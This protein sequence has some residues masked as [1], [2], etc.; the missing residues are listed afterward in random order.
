MVTAHHQHQHLLVHHRRPNLD[1]SHRHHL[2]V[3]DRVPQCVRRV[4]HLQS[5]YSVLILIG[6]RWLA[7]LSALLVAQ[8]M[9]SATIS[10]AVL[11][12]SSAV[13]SI[14]HKSNHILFISSSDSHHHLRLCRIFSIVTKCLNISETLG[15]F[16]IR[17]RHIPQFYSRILDSLAYQ[18]VLV[19]Y[20]WQFSYQLW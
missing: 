3:V 10:A 17:F 12:P 7:I 11:L 6:S 5:I 14:F 8:A 20:M 1:C 16:G 2:D 15:Y 9:Y 18:F 19:V 13:L 4:H